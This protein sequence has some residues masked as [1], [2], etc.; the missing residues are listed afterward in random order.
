MRTGSHYVLLYLNAAHMISL[1]RNCIH[2]FVVLF[3][4]IMEFVQQNNYTLFQ[5]YCDCCAY[6]NNNKKI[7]DI[8]MHSQ[9][10]TL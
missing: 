2:K 6:H 10:C 5:F 1:S 4:I 9:F 8:I 7:N 3:E